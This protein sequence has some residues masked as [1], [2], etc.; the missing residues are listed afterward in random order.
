VPGTSTPATVNVENSDE[1]VGLG[2]TEVAT[3][4]IIANYSATETHTGSSAA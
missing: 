3:P 1:D 2:V 4:N